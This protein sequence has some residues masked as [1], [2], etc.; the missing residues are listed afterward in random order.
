MASHPRR[1]YSLVTAA[2]PPKAKQ[3]AEE[4]R[5]YL[6]QLEK[7]Y[8]GKL[9]WVFKHNPLPFHNRALPASVFAYDVYKQ[10][11]IRYRGERLMKKVG[12]AAGK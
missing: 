11:G 6:E 3:S 5:K 1:S 9:R 12:K 8:Q 7:D 4:A 10:K 2:S